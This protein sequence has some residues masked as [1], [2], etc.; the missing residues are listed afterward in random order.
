MK[1]NIIPYTKHYIDDEDIQSVVDVLKSNKITQ[2]ERVL[3]FENL[4]STFCGA[5]YAVV[6]SSGTAALHIASLSLLHKNDKV[7]T[8]PNSFVATANS[9][10]YA[11]AKP[12]FVDIAKD[13]NIDLEL[14]QEILEK[15]DEIKAIYAVSFS[16]NMLNQ[17]KLKY[18]KDRYNILI[19]EDCAHSLGAVQ[20]GIKSTS[21]TNSDISIL[22]FHPAKHITTA[23]GGAILT[24]DKSIFMQ[25]KALK[26][27]GITKN[28]D[29]KPWEYQMNSLGFN[30][31]MSDLQ[32]A[33]GISQLKKIDNFI[34]KQK[35]LAKNYDKA[36]SN[37]LVKPLYKYTDDS[38]YHIYVVQVDFSKLKI[39]KELFFNLLK[40]KNII[41]QNHYIPINK[42]PY[43]INLGYGSENTPTMDRYYKQCFSLPLYYQLTTKIQHYVIDLVLK[44][45][46]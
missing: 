39:T 22:S 6:V 3:E 41:I 8:T 16:G 19:L 10:L 28:L 9:I 20:N 25:L 23:E 5:K 4:L 14:C 18:L 1:N 44:L 34:K 21:C 36:F 30:Y 29:S 32:C 46:K 40:E 38:S 42:Q 24:N 7:L 15:D 13:G 35:T 12:I 2:G 33:L 27:H 37:T 17:K 26:E 11:G 43:Y 45:L 31:R